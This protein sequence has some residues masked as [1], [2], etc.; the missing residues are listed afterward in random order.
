MIYLTLT[1]QTSFDD[2]IRLLDQNGSGFLPVVY[3]DQTLVGI[4]TD[5][6]VRRNLLNR[7]FQLDS[8]IN[9]NPHTGKTGISHVHIKRRLR[10]L[11]LRHM[12]VVDDRN[13]LVEVV[14]LEE[15][16]HAHRSNWVVV[17]AGG[18][19][20]RLG[21]LTR[22]MPKPMLEVAGKPILL[23]IVEHFK[24]QGY[25]RFI[26]CVNYKS[27][28][29]QNYFGDGSPFGITIRYTLEKK[30]MGTAGALSLIDFEL[31]EPF[32]VVNGDVI[33]AIDYDD[34]LNHHQVNGASATMCVKRFP[35]DIPYACVDF[36]QQFDLVGLREK[37]TFSYHVNTGMYVLEPS[38]LSSIP[39]D[40]FFD[41]TMLFQD[42][43]DKRLPAKV[44]T[45]D[46]YWLDVGK[47]EDY[48]KAG[49]RFSSP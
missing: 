40:S 24:S 32:F 22:S 14:S 8:I 29:I 7:N 42:L 13:R 41:M 20:T 25:V 39:S 45:I 49:K 15:F 48:I 21:E 10:E 30:P 43:L 38:L 18:M 27:E 44:F 31:S 46:D 34:F 9:R 12:P 6:D 16:E 47:P 37:P 28:V 23:R 2:A 17:M 35:V 19:G 26:F 3:P 4:I 5:G 1:E 11:N 33:T 36:S